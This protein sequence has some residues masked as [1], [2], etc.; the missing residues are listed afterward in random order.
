MG[1]LDSLPPPTPTPQAAMPA[2]TSAAV[3]P[4]AAEPAPFVQP[5]DGNAFR[6]RIADALATLGVD[7]QRVAVSLLE[8]LEFAAQ[9]YAGA[10]TSSADK[11]YWQQMGYRLFA[12]LAA[13]EQ[14]D[15]S[16]VHNKLA[17]LD[18]RLTTVA[19]DLDG[20]VDKKKS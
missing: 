7:P 9:A 14:G 8:Q 20:K 1:L 18:T 16:E 6:Q 13:L 5:E 15:N 4:Q 11:Q 3:A 12:K 19:S 17:D 10:M 2:S